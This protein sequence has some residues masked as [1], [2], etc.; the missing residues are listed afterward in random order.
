MAPAAAGVAGAGAGA[1][2]A[3]AY[4]QRRQQKDSVVPE[5]EAVLPFEKDAEQDGGLIVPKGVQGQAASNASIMAVKSPAGSTPSAESAVLAGPMGSSG[6]VVVE[7]AAEPH[8]VAEPST[9]VQTNSTLGGLEAH[10]ARETGKLPTMVRHD[11]D[12]SISALHVPGEFPR[13]DRI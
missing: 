1:L 6:G 11:T 13:K 5:N 10:G 12:L 3:E 9:D 8:A 2:G 7:D 4:I